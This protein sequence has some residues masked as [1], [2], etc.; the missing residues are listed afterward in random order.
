[1]QIIQYTFFYINYSDTRMER[2]T[3]GC[4][5]IIHSD[6]GVPNRLGIGIDIASKPHLR[7]CFLKFWWSIYPLLLGLGKSWSTSSRSCAVLI[8]LFLVSVLQSQILNVTCW[9][10]PLFMARRAIPM[11]AFPRVRCMFIYIS[12]LLL[13][14]CYVL[15]FSYK[16]V[17][18]HN[19]L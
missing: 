12:S 1:M 11:I 13:C 8:H 19:A 6:F 2:L 5:I 4:S 17:I 18:A 14:C 16:E 10:S 3:C 9:S 7:S 15:Y